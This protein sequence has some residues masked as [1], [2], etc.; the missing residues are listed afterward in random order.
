[1][2]YLVALTGGIGSGKST[3]ANAFSRLGVTVIDADVIARQVVEP[4]TPALSA[5]AAHFGEALLHPDGSLNRARLRE[6]IFADPTEKT[7]L[8]SLLHPLI[9]QE[10]QRRIQQATTPYVLWVVPLLVENGL[11]TRA[12]RVLVIDVDRETQLVRTTARD[13]VSRQQAENI[14]AAQVTREQRLACADDVI[15][16][17]G[18]PSAIGPRVAALHQHYLQLA[19]ATQQD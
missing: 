18:D 6:L 11:Q 17:S 4:G 1:M 8:N 5:I 13:G 7:W 2:S 16:N 12:D 10:T 19:A 3:V 9:Q 15:D 14:L